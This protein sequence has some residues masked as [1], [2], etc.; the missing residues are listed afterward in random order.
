MN[1]QT[2]HQHHP[3]GIVCIKLWRFHHCQHW[4]P[5]QS[6]NNLHNSTNQ[7]LMPT[8]G[9]C[10]NKPWQQPHT[11]QTEIVACT[12]TNTGHWVMY[13]APMKASS[14]LALSAKAIYWGLTWINKPSTNAGYQ[15]LYKRALKVAIYKSNRNCSTHKHNCQPL[16][17]VQAS[18]E[19]SHIQTKQK[20]KHAQAQLPATGY[21]MYKA[22]IK[23]SPLS[24]LSEK[25]IY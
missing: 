25:A 22:L 18:F 4:A 2:K 11:N 20:L 19:S 8:T 15:V 7:A 1:Q 17:I 12:N 13:K 10:L 5:K 23:A 9:Y 24:T 21:Q 14:L 6:I 3:P 16:S